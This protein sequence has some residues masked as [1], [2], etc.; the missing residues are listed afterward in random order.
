MGQFNYYWQ[1]IGKDMDKLI[2][3]INDL[4]ESGWSCKNTLDYKR[5]MPRVVQILTTAIDYETAREFS[6]LQKHGPSNWDQ[7]LPSQ[8]GFLEGL[9][10]KIESEMTIGKS[11]DVHDP[12]NDG[13]TIT[14]TNKVFIVHGHD[15]DAKETVARYVEKLGLDPIVLHEQPSGGRT[16]IEKFEVFSDVGFSVVLLT[17][18]DVGASK[19]NP[20]QFNDRARQ[21]VILELGYFLGKLGRDRV[22]ALY[23]SGVEMPSDYQGVVYT[24]I[25]IAGGWKTTLA[26]EFVEA[27]FKINLNAIIGK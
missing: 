4:I 10:L 19:A 5:W 6:T 27:G 17:P 2:V 15:T 26:Q 1:S 16:I 12:V 8:T 25:D 11:P 22:C 23:K 24:E 3:K 7:D 18:D 20:E 21:N 14:K 13:L 9:A